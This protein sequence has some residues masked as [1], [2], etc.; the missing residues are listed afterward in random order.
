MS[1]SR[2]SCFNGCPAQYKYKYIDELTLIEKREFQN[3]SLFGSAIHRGLQVHYQGGDVSKVKEAFKEVYSS[4]LSP[5]DEAKSLE[6]GLLCL[7]AYIAHYREMDKD[8]R[9]IETELKD[10]V[11]NGEDSHNLVVDLI[12]EHIPSKTIYAWDHKTVGAEKMK[13]G[14]W[15]RYELDAQ[16]TMY[17]EY[18]R[19][20]YGSCAGFYVNAI[21][22]GHR[23]R[24]YKGEPAGYYQRFERNLFERSDEQIDAWK[25][26]DSEWRALM[27]YAMASGSYPKALNGLCGYCE[28]QQLCL[29]ADNEQVKEIMYQQKKKAV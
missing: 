4:D 2:V 20:K 7:E 13:Y 18:I 11:L 24:M 15:K 9:V 26:S 12:A 14:F 6:G 21:A 17:T 23:K 25:K 10:T 8:W 22:V 27:D 5:A 1:H 28:F 3:D 16:V 19:Q 29:S